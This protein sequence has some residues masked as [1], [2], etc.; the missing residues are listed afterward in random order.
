[1]L[2][3]AIAKAEQQHP[4]I[5]PDLRQ[6]PTL[7]LGSDYGGMHRSADF[8][9]ITLIA[10]NL[11]TIHTWD[12]ARSTVRDRLLPDRRRISFKTLNDCHQRSA[13]GPFLEA[14]NQ[15]RGLLFT[16]AIHRRV[17]S[18]FKKHD[19]LRKTDLDS[20]ELEGWKT[21]TAERALRVIHLASLLVR[22]LSR[23]GQDV[24][25]ITD[26]DEIVANEGRLRSF[27][28]LFVTVSG[29]Y[30]PH[31]MRHVRIGT[32]IS[33]TGRRD[34]E[35]FVAVCDLAAGALQYYLTDEGA[36]VVLNAPSLFLP[37]EQKSSSKA[38]VILDW[39]S[40]NECLLKRLTFIL[41]ESTTGQLRITT[42]RLHGSNDQT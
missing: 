41:D 34:V 20:P 17:Q 5:I 26:Q 30:I 23:T 6:T 8:E 13:I 9:V 38:S 35:D 32:T 33:D 10:S 22:G 7:L 25:W 14:A 1:M 18:V 21:T 28:K 3:A 4:G 27:V 2:S 15:L 29:H 31:A 37:R 42:L 36:Q 12:R 16:V 19:K 24:L 40:D 11:E 39:F